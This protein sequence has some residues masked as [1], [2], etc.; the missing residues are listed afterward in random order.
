MA[1]NG[2]EVKVD[3][4]F[5]MDITEISPEYRNEDGITEIVEEVLSACAYDIPGSEIK[6]IA[7]HIEGLD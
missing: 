3:M 5:E 1:T 7:V 6:R 4:L 2:I